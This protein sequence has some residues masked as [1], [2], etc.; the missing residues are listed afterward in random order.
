MKASM[1]SQQINERVPRALAA[2]AVSLVVLA[3][4][5][6]CGGST[7][8]T[9]N[10]QA[11]QASSSQPT[12]PTAAGSKAAA[13]PA[14]ASTSTAATQ[15]SPAPKSERAPANEKIVLSSPAIDPNGGLLQAR[16]TCDGQNIPL[17][18]KWR[19]VP[20]G[21]AELMIDVM[22][23]K[24]LNKKLQFSWAVTHIPSTTH[25]IVEGK[26]PQGAVVG[27]NSR[28]E[29]SYRLCPPKGPAESYVAVIFALPHRLSARA[30]FD[31]RA[32]RREAEQQASYQNLLIFNYRRR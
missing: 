4:L 30:G 8:T 20:P 29:T 10:S 31:P 7:T 11:T 12:A 9:T 6:G 27:T 2:M 5:L 24:P 18:L 15:A 1:G 25:E 22:G 14:P 19:G 26:L 21:T 16:Y 3:S 13:P 32:L 17:P 28:G 23:V